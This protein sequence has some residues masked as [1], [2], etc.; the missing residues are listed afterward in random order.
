M[1]QGSSSDW[2][3][4]SKSGILRALNT[5][6]VITGPTAVGKTSLAIEWARAYDAEIVSCDSLL[7]YRGM[8][9]GT[10]KP[11]VEELAAVSHHCI[12]LVEPD[13][14]FNVSTY[15]KEAK[16]AVDSILSRGKRVLVTGGSGFY[17]KGF[18]APVVDEIEIPPSIEDEVDRLYRESGLEAVVE[19]L[20]QCSP[21]DYQLIDLQ[22]SRRVIP[23]LKRCMTTGLSITAL[24]ESVARG[25]YPFQNFGKQ[26]LYLRRSIDDL[27]DRI[28][29]RTRIMLEAGLVEEVEQLLKCGIESNPSASNSIGYREVIAFLKGNLERSMLEQT[30]NAN[31]LKLVK[32]QLKWFRHQI[33]FTHMVDLEAGTPSMDQLFDGPSSV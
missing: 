6:Y 28:S 17:L 9:I 8:D 25:P 18:L 11:T 22:N 30:I 12:D 10:A 14:S 4:L 13:Q 32:K 23:A 21:D 15:L 16:N 20:K 1:V 19:G 5:I 33:E 31:T 7:V 26:V 2:M 3:R 29:R 27:Q 24:R